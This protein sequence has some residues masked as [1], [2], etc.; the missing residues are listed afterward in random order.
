MSNKV[1]KYL[2]WNLAQ[3]KNASV[4]YKCQRILE[5][6]KTWRR[7]RR[8]QKTSSGE[9]LTNGQREV[10]LPAVVQ[11]GFLIKTIIMRIWWLSRKTTCGLFF[12]ESKQPLIYSMLSRWGW[13]PALTSPMFAVRLTTLTTTTSRR[14]PGTK[15]KGQWRETL[16]SAFKKL[17]S[18]L[19]FCV[20]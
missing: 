17:L 18:L 11:H 4:S 15:L 19:F 13:C 6:L 3:A 1:S 16:A 20:W 14:P 12:H 2:I 7:H 5:G 8:R 9:S 10:G